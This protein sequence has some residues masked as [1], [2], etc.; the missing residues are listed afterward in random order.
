M[1]RSEFLALRW[2][3]IDLLAMTASVN[4]TLQQL[5]GGELIF[6]PTKTEKSNRLIDLTPANC[7]VLRDYRAKQEQLRQSLYS[8][9]CSKCHKNNWDR[10]KIGILKCLDCG[11]VVPTIKNE[12]LVFSHYDGSPYQPD[13]V[14]HAWTRLIRQNGLS[15]IRLHDARH[16]HATIMIK[17]GVPIKVVQ[18]RMGHS[19]ISTTMDIYAHV[20]PGMQAA[21]AVKFDEF[22]K[23]KES[24][25]ERELN[26]IVKN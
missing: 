14:T 7:V 25:L 22:L 12:D 4:R 11:N 3:D 21:A 23:P 13:S 8:D 17:N 18:E 2:N 15:G 6:K 19:S 20:T 26:E 10:A 1:R 9:D 24:K 16:S 5:K